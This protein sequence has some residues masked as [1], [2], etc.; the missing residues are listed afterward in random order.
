MGEE[1]I[2]YGCK[3]D[4]DGPNVNRKSIASKLLDL[5]HCISSPSSNEPNEFTDMVKALV[6]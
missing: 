6:H 2:S 1:Q 4:K 5:G 3:S